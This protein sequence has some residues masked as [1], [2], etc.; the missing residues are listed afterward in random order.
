MQFYIVLFFLCIV[1]LSQEDCNVCVLFHDKNV[2]LKTFRGYVHIYSFYTY[3]MWCQLMQCA[4][5]CNLIVK[6]INKV[7]M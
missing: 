2:L 3:N 6:L 1:N 5:G 7:I 4:N